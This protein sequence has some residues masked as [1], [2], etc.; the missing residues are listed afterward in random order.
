MDETAVRVRGG[1]HYLYRAVDK[2]GKSVGSLLCA[3]RDMESSRKFFLTA[4]A[5]NRN[6]WPSI[7]NVDGNAATRRA[8]RLLGRRSSN[9]RSVTVRCSRYLNNLIEQDHRA[10]KR[11]CA[12]MLSLKSFA[13]AAI[14]LAGIE[15]AHRI[16]KRQ[17]L[18]GRAP[19]GKHVSMKE[20]W[21]Q[22]LSKSPHVVASRDGLSPEQPP[23]H[24]ISRIITFSMQH[25]RHC[26]KPLR[27]A[28]KILDGRGLYQL[29]MPNGS[30]YWRYN[31]RFN[32][33]QKTIALG[34]YPDV[35]LRR[36]G[37]DTKLC[38]RCLPM[39]SIH[40]CESRRWAS[41]GAVV[42]GRSASARC[43]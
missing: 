2:R 14:T 30:R 35:S 40:W 9:W 42:D 5:A 37:H 39:G 15:L 24:H 32:G 26:A 20:I 22:A 27:Y 34:V 21:D 18:V 38:A 7:V 23:M 43:A 11:R 12:S 25:G 10:I 6:K 4:V 29:L 41:L 28:R 31:Y 1:T 17:F 3:S 8:L 13:T 16:R 33:K 36:P 19:P